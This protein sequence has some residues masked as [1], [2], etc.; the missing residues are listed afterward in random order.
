MSDEFV[1]FARSENG[2]TWSIGRHQVSGFAYVVH[3]GNQSSGGHREELDLSSFLGTTNADSP[4]RCRL[5]RLLG[6]WA[7]SATT[8]PSPPFPP[9]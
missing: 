6:A 1:E 8:G 3:E 7:Q 4:E 9:G 2:D 5:L